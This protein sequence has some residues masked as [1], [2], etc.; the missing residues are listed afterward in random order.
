MTNDECQMTKEIGSVLDR[1]GLKKGKMNKASLKKLRWVQCAARI[2][3]AIIVLAIVVAPFL[4]LSG[5]VK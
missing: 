5:W 3:L 2:I 1:E 4:G